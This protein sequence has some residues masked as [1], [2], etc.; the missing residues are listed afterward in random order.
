MQGVGSIALAI[1]S[2]QCGGACHLAR[3]RL[4]QMFNLL[5]KTAHNGQASEGWYIVSSGGI[6]LSMLC[7]NAMAMAA[8]AYCPC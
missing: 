8:P 2:A 6:N 7:A 5:N 3:W 4:N 1:A